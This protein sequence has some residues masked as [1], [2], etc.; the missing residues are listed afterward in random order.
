MFRKWDFKKAL[1]LDSLFSSLCPLWS[2]ILSS[3][4]NILMGTV[5]NFFYSRLINCYNCGEKLSQYTTFQVGHKFYV[6]TKEILYLF[7]LMVTPDLFVECQTSTLFIPAKTFVKP[8]KDRL[9]PVNLYYRM[10]GKLDLHK[11]V[12]LLQSIRFTKCWFYAFICSLSFE[13]NGGRH[14]TY[15][16]FEIKC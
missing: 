6:E 12:N 13:S 9:F 16:H 11:Y 5:C 7:L 2:I 8:K 10:Y 15:E 14:Q 3:I 4:Q 1:T